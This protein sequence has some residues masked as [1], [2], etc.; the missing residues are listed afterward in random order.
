MLLPR[1]VG[2]ALRK[3]CASSPKAATNRRTEQRRPRASSS[4]CR[5]RGIVAQGVR[6]AL[7]DLG[8]VAREP[9]L[10]DG[11]HVGG[12]GHRVREPA[13]LVG[14]Q[15]AGQGHM[16]ARRPTLRARSASGTS[17]ARARGARDPAGNLARRAGLGGTQ[18]QQAREA[19]SRPPSAGRTA[20][21]GGRRSRRRAR[22][23][24]AAAGAPPPAR[25]WPAPG[26]RRR[27]RAPGR[28]A[29]PGRRSPG[30]P[31]QPL[32]HLGAQR[33]EPHRRGCCTSAGKIGRIG[34][35]Y[36]RR[37]AGVRK[38]SGSSPAA[39]MKENERKRRDSNPRVPVKGT[40][41]FRDR[42]N[43]PLCH[44]SWTEPVGGGESWNRT[45]SACTPWE[46][47]RTERGRGREDQ[48]LVYHQ[49]PGHPANSP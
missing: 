47:L 42:C 8:P 41:G 10:A 33:I 4:A 32:S 7:L 40:S 3:Q 45:T 34:G 27:P 12:E 38:E 48:R 11:E 23:G 31:A 26:L 19:R 36:P 1:P 13:G 20:P 14:T 9:G 28:A 37:G 29:R 44:A 30:D 22:R 35:G 17:R 6:E 25:P 49:R 15:R 46:G 39:P 2:V 18:G 5:T 43:R 24:R 21:G 16:D